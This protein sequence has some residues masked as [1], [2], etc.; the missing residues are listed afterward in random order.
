MTKQIILLGVLH[1][2]LR[3]SGRLNDA[4]ERTK[5]DSIAIEFYEELAERL[6]SEHEKVIRSSDDE[7]RRILEEEGFNSR[8]VDMMTARR[9]FESEGFEAWISREYARKMDVPITYL[10]TKDSHREAWDES[11]EFRNRNRS[12]EIAYYQ[13][14]LEMPPL[15]A[16]AEIDTH[17]R[18]PGDD[19]LANTTKRN[20]LWIPKITALRGRIL[21]IAGLA[22]THGANPNLCELL[23][24]EEVLPF[25][26]NDFV[27][28]T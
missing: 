2:D 16:I 12:T 3:G 15:R 10:D 17:Y 11:R 28:D 5:P 26:L 25:K 9:Y 14:V 8:T 19:D 22:H 1:N 27:S 4:L 13:T 24:E 6:E 7:I 20:G 21:T 18:V 23:S